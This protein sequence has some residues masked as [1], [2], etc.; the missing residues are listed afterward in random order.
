[1]TSAKLYIYIGAGA[2][3][4]YIEEAH[5]ALD[6]FPFAAFFELKFQHKNYLW[7]RSLIT[8]LA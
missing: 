6:I 3:V 2:R 1:M 8:M 5:T 7:R 4:L